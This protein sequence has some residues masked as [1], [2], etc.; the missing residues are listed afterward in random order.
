M[1]KRFF[2]LLPISILILFCFVFSACNF[3]D[4][5]ENTDGEEIYFNIIYDYSSLLPVT[6]ERV[7]KGTILTEPESPQA[8]GYKFSGWYLE[9]DYIN[10]FTFGNAVT[11]DIYLYAKWESIYTGIYKETTDSGNINSLTLNSNGTFLLSQTEK[12]DTFIYSGTYKND[13]ENLILISDKV[14]YNE[15]YKE[16]ENLFLYSVNDYAI[17]DGEIVF[18]KSD[19]AAP[20]LIIGRYIKTL[21]N[22]VEIIE[23]SDNGTYKLIYLFYD[24][25]SESVK[26]TEM[27][28]NYR[29]SE[30]ILFMGNTSG[31]ETEFEIKSGYIINTVDNAVYFYKNQNNKK[32]VAGFLVNFDGFITDITQT[33][34][35]RI[36]A[37]DNK[38][39]EYTINVTSNMIYTSKASV[40]AKIYVE[41][42]NLVFL[43]NLTICNSITVGE[44]AELTVNKNTL[45]CD[46]YKAQAESQYGIVFSSFLESSANYTLECESKAVISLSIYDKDGNMILK[47]YNPDNIIEL[48][49]SPYK[50]DEYYYVI[51]FEVS[52][53]YEENINITLKNN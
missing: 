13:K 42:E 41:N 50:S 18:V 38:Y 12:N 29:I 40:N 3:N 7:K 27:T 48:T 32:Y 26:K 4:V 17:T 5:P 20:S 37:F 30:N 21:K 33:D 15:I 43:K 47:K 10:K 36:I 19:A 25:S 14:K 31:K 28:N 16:E 11:S 53:G 22:N 44:K 46:K 9:E 8:D 39:E 1:K 35:G 52:D 51:V 2:L 23:F 49:Y 6:S 34:Y 45:L 24:E